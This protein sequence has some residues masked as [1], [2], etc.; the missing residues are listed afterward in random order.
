M[1]VA[2]KGDHAM[3][4]ECWCC[5]TAYPESRLV[6]LGQ[7]PEVGVCQG[8]A[9][10]LRRRA[11]QQSA[12]RISG[13]VHSLGERIRETVMAHGWQHRPIVGPVLRALGRLSPWRFPW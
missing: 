12:G 9:D 10:F 3:E 13:T 4:S 8:C 6:R 2:A 11:R 1:S 7:H 5:G